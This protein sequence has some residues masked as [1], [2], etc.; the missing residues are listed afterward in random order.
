MKKVEHDNPDSTV[1]AK[2]D[3][4]FRLRLSFTTSSS[5]KSAYTSVLKV[6]D[7]FSVL[8]NEPVM[9]TTITVP[10]GQGMTLDLY[11][12]SIKDQRSIDLCKQRKPHHQMALNAET[13]SLERMFEKWFNEDIIDPVVISSIQNETNIPDINKTY[14]E[15]V[16]FATQLE[17]ITE[18]DGEKG[19]KYVYPFKKYAAGFI[20]K[21]LLALFGL[22]SLDDLG[23]EISNLRAE[24]AH[25]KR[26]K[27]WLKRLEHRKLVHVTQYLHLTILGHA[28]SKLGISDDLIHQYQIKNRPR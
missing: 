19:G 3:L 9:P 12:S 24:V 6:S 1:F 21:E 28:L 22:S 8:I 15:I 16:L 10:F 2:R 11:P 25:L 18:N 20:I 4:H 7:L 23:A 27:V 14:G 5:I 26:K 13:V 17:F